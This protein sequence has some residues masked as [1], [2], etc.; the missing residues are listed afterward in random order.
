MKQLLPKFCLWLIIVI[1][2]ANKGIWYSIFDFARDHPTTTT[3]SK[4]ILIAGRSKLGNVFFFFLSL[5]LIMMYY[6]IY[7]LI[8]IFKGL[9]LSLVN[10]GEFT[11]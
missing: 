3:M 5:N 10:L 8:C 11:R 2:L 7:S 1:S 6:N 4:L 9:C